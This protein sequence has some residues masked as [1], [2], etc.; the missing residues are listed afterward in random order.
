MSDDKY[1]PLELYESQEFDF[2]E[3]EERNIL[4]K[5]EWIYVDMFDDNDAA[6]LWLK[7][8]TK[9]SKEDTY[10]TKKALVYQPKYIKMSQAT[11]STPATSKPTAKPTRKRKQTEVTENTDE[12]SNKKP[13]IGEYQVSDLILK[14][15]RG[16][17]RPRKN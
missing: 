9:W 12:I 16:R 11:T 5:R 10:S 14:A 8:E 1:V 4:K 6:D 17:V 7:N 2:E 15:K 13:K 3:L